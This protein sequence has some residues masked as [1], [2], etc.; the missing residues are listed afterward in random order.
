MELSRKKIT[1]IML[2]ILTVV[3]AAALFA[4]WNDAFNRIMIL[5]D[6]AVLI[7][8]GLLNNILSDKRIIIILCVN[9]VSLMITMMYHHSFGVTIVFLNLLLACFVFNQ[10]QVDRR[11]YQLMHLICAV[12][13]TIISLSAKKGIF[14][15]NGGTEIFNYQ[16]LGVVLQKN[17]VG[18]TALGSMFHWACL[19][20]LF[21][22][23]RLNKI[24][25]MI[26]VFVV[27]IN[28][29]IESKCRSAM[30]AAIAFGVLYIIVWSDI[31]Y[32]F[33]YLI[34]L[35]IIV[36]SGLYT[37]YYVKNIVELDLED[38]MGLSTFSRLGTWN[39]ALALIYKYP[40]FGSGTDMKMTIY[41]SAHNTVLSI[42]KTVGIIPTVT[43]AFCLVKRFKPDIKKASYS[44]VS[45]IALIAGMA[46]SFFESYYVESFFSI[47][48]LIF[49]IN[50][51]PEEERDTE[52][53]PLLLVRPEK[54]A[55]SL[56]KIY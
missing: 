3:S 6:M 53:N 1:S 16:S 34:V 25:V 11:T 22:V 47:V 18:I 32:R 52:D 17:F 48:F 7:F 36:A 19:I 38:V 56:S 4:Y 31:P 2:I 42:L 55:G 15:V 8:L 37:I 5:F 12:L 23:K 49:L 24:L 40:I 43:Y 27:F 26:F 13:W 45:Q 14:P 54:D 39:A 46:V 50:P 35:G 9:L 33:Y 30:I 29:I 20:E 44:R 41:D 21:R 28:K 51:E 10:I